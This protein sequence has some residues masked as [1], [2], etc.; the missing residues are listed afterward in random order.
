MLFRYAR[1]ENLMESYEEHIKMLEALRNKDKDL[2]L[3]LMDRNIQ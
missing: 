1:H 2:L 3:E